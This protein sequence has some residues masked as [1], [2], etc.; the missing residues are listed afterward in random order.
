MASDFDHHLTK[1]AGADEIAAL[2]QL[3][4]SRSPERPRNGHRRLTGFFNSRSAPIPHGRSGA[5]LQLWS[6]A[7]GLPRNVRAIPKMLIAIQAISSTN[8]EILN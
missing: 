7:G 8:T 1:P 4:G 3:A 5:R 2:A 6:G